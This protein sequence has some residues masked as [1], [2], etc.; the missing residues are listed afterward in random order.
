MPWDTPT[1]TFI[2][3]N[4]RN[5]GPTVWDE[6]AIALQDI[7]SQGHD[8]HDQDL[9][10]G[11]T[12]C[13]NING[14]NAM[15]TDLSMGGFK[16]TGIADAVVDTDAVS[17]SQL[18]D[19]GTIA[20][21]ADSKADTNATNIAVN[22]VNIDANAQNIVTNSNNILTLAEKDVDGVSWAS[23]VISLS[24]VSDTDLTA[25]IEVFDSFKSNGAIRH[26]FVDDGTGTQTIDTAAA[27][28]HA[29]VNDGALTLT[30][31]KPTGADADLGENYQV[32]GQVL[33]TNGA[34][35]GAITIAGAG[36]NDVLGE[37]PNTA[38]AKYLLSYIIQRSTGDAYN[39]LYIYSAVA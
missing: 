9:A 37:A 29:L 27:T 32:E 35:P 21:G 8:D 30:F 28:R 34:T 31:T 6:D 26:K 18:D 16:V 2:R 12:A 1:K 36:A 39:E 33:I 10:N 23:N 24:R 22:A 25:T 14:V 15:L 38:S 11:I 4:G 13:L 7:D 5:S 3:N 20:V 17:K 19:V